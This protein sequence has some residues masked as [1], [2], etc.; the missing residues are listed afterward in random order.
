MPAA[1]YTTPAGTLV[2]VLA[3]RGSEIELGNALLSAIPVDQFKLSPAFHG[4]NPYPL[5]NLTYREY[6]IF[7]PTLS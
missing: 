6:S 3:Q 2:R 4:I 5:S 1:V 7:E